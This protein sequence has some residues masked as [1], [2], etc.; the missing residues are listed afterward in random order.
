MSNLTPERFLQEVAGHQM[1]VVRDDGI[2][3]HVRFKRPDTICMHFDLIT[4][5]GY[6]C[7]SGDMGTYVFTRL[8]DMFD[9]FRRSQS[10]DLFAIDMRYWAEKVE[11][12]ARASRGNGVTEFSKAKFDASVREWVEDFAKTER[13]EAAG[14]EEPEVVELCARA[15]GDL[16]SAVEREVI[17]AD[18]ND[19]RCFDAA[20]DFS[21]GADDSDA[22]SAYFGHETTFEFTDFW[23]VDHNEFTHRFQWCCFAL[24]WGI[25]QYDES[26]VA[27][28]A[29]KGDEVPA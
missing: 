9:F 23:E 19:I 8:R 17:G 26:K 27:V 7:Y 13:N 5:P 12:G 16:R 3:R 25:K 24:A 20:N 10:K 22:W 1:T 29:A 18:D 14:S 11:A 6:L 2:Y 21:F 28:G 15:L 4:W